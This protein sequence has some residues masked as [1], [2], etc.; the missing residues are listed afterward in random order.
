[1]NP[2]TEDGHW[3]CAIYSNLCN[4]FTSHWKPTKASCDLILVKSLNWRSPW[5]GVILNPSDWEHS[6]PEPK[7]NPR[8]WTMVSLVPERW[9]KPQSLK[10]VKVTLN[11]PWKTKTTLN[12]AHSNPWSLNS[13]AWTRMGRWTNTPWTWITLEETEKLGLFGIMSS[14]LLQ[15]QGDGRIKEGY[16]KWVWNGIWEELITLVPEHKWDWTRVS[17]MVQNQSVSDE[18]LE[19]DETLEPHNHIKLI[20][21]T[22]R[23]RFEPEKPKPPDN[24]KSQPVSLR[25]FVYSNRGRLLGQ[26]FTQIFLTSIW[27]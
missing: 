18:T 21:C 11:S 12:V 9:L 6:G 5:A 1:M 27:T 4:I 8:P 22:W 14:Q 10:R 25:L 2:I 7:L 16:V 13:L 3:T 19:H 24:Q 23:S 20:P 15:H 17:N 26:Y